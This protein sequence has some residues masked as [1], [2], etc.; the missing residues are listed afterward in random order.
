MLFDLRGRRRRAVQVTYVTLAVLMGGGLVFFGIGGGTSGG[1][2]DAFKGGG[3]GGGGNDLVEKRIERNEKRVQRNPKDERA[4]KRLVRDYYQ[5]ATAQTTSNSTGFP[6]EAKDEL[7]GAASWWQRY[8]KAESGKPDPSLATVALQIYDVIGLNKPK[9]AKEA[10][11]IIADAQN[12]ASAYLRLVQYAALAGDTRTAD[13]AGE[14]AVDLA[15]RG[16]KKQVEA[17]VKQLKNPQAATGA[18][19]G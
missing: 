8:L 4:L 16:Q 3:G 6:A 7:Q 15:P 12:D 1:L 17:Q 9:Q 10:A 2:L 14:K 11:A 18:Q 13:L 19:G 5:L